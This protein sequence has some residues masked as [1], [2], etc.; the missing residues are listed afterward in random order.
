MGGRGGAWLH[1][2]FGVALGRQYIDFDQYVRWTANLVDAG[3]NY[4]GVSGAVLAQA[5]RLDAACGDAPGHLFRTLSKMIGGRAAE[6]HSHV[7]AV[8]D[9]LRDLWGDH[10][11]IGYR[12]PV[13]GHLLSALIREREGDYG[14]IM[15]TVLARSRDT[16]AL[17]DYIRSWL[18]GHF[19]FDSVLRKRQ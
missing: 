6:P 17:S 11:T 1:V 2:V 12:H 7:G 4:L 5:A 15:R 16:V 8:V 13:T 19:L 18:L 14:I 9:C 10:R 3:H